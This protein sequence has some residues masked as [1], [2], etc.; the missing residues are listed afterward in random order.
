VG[1]AAQMGTHTAGRALPMGSAM[2]FCENSRPSSVPPGFEVP[3][4]SQ[5]GTPPGHPLFGGTP[6]GGGGEK[7]RV[8]TT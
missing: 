3:L 8:V 2:L 7:P 5:P 4:S 6:L 1:R